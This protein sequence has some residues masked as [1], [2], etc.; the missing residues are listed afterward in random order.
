MELYAPD[1]IYSEI[2]NI[3]WKKWKRGEIDAE[4]IYTLIGD[5]KAVDL[6]IYRTDKL[7]SMAWDI[8]RKYDRTFY[9]SLYI[10]L[11]VKHECRVVTADLKLFNALKAT[12]LK[13]H[14]LWIG[15]ISI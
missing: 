3:L 4:D 12:S 13:K 15:D 11:A 1:L 9:D 14:I 2:G 8:A 10:A 6:N 7:M 5:F